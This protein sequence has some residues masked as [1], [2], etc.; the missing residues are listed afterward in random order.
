MDKW[1]NLP[2]RMS[3]LCLEGQWSWTVISVSAVRAGKACPLQRQEGAAPWPSCHLPPLLSC[4]GKD[5][6]PLTILGEMPR[7]HRVLGICR[8]SSGALPLWLNGMETPISLC[9][10]PGRTEAGRQGV[11]LSCYFKCCG[12]P[13]WL[14]LPPHPALDA[15]CPPAM[16][17]TL[18]EEPTEEKKCRA[19]ICSEGNLHILLGKCDRRR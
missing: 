5:K 11:V 13:E 7:G 2:V 17:G 8:S 14:C 16:V 9:W 10:S 18:G 12:Q 4:S 3:G 1:R 19:G 15:S 6:G